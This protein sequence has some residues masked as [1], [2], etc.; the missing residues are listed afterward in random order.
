MNPG[1]GKRLPADTAR[2]KICGPM[3]DPTI[4]VRAAQR[5]KDS[6]RRIA[7]QEAMLAARMER[8][9]FIGDLERVIRSLR[10]TQTLFEEHYRALGGKI[11]D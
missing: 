7:Q 10:E 8:G 2:C 6:R 11:E 5:L 3:Q 9:V 1:V 4:L